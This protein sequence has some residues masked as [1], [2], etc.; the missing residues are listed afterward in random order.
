MGHENSEAGGRCA[1][2]AVSVTAA[3]PATAEATAEAM[4]PCLEA[5]SSL[6]TAVTWATLI[7]TGEGLWPC[8]RGAWCTTLGGGEG[9]VSVCVA[10]GASPESPGC[11]VLRD[12]GKA[13]AFLRARKRVAAPPA[14][15]FF[16]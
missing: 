11:A 13:R 7:C 6:Q 2:A 14:T 9:R 1:A 8:E 5:A 10:G 12:Q 4:C 16:R 3:C 15:F